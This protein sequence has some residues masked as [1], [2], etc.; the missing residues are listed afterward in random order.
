MKTI[1]D[2]CDKDEFKRRFMR[3]VRADAMTGCI[4]WV[5]SIGFG[6]YGRFCFESIAWSAHRVAYE[7]VNGQIEQSGAGWFVLHRCDNPCC[8]NP[9][10]LYVGSAKDNAMDAANRKRLL[11]TAR[12]IS[13]SYGKHGEDKYVGTVFYE[14]N[15]EVKTLK[16]WSKLL[17]VNESTLDQR[18]LAGWP[19]QS[20]SMPSSKYKRH[21]REECIFEYKRFSGEKEV[22]QYLSAH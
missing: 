16:E 14:F 22:Q 8:C 11:H 7:L 12:T 2:V 4:N 19:P 6:G 15:G 10:H 9:D 13:A 3:K 18:F 20:I 17:G 5:G 21:T 1:S